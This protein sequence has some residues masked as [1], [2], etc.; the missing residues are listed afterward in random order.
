MRHIL[1]PHTA[2]RCSIPMNLSPHGICKLSSDFDG[3]GT[4][5]ATKHY[6]IPRHLE[7]HRGCSMHIH[8][9][10]DVVRPAPGRRMYSHQAVVFSLEVPRS[11][12]SAAFG[13]LSPFVVF[14]SLAYKPVEPSSSSSFDRRIRI[15]SPSLITILVMARG[16]GVD[17]T[18]L[19]TGTITP[20]K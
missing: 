15:R 16:S 1:T 8:R 20:S 19:R 5:A 2:C 17:P 12:R 18:M 10:G 7:A 9:P 3:R 14:I 11:V 4:D 6:G 13:H